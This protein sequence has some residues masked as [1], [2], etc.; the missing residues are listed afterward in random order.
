MRTRSG[1]AEVLPFPRS[2][3]FP[4]QAPVGVQHF[5][6][7]AQPAAPLPFPARPRGQ[8]EQLGQI[9]RNMRLAMKV[10]RETIARRLAISTATIDAF[11][12]G[13][14]AALPHWKET[15]RVVRGYC[16]LLRLDPEPILWRIRSQ[17]QAMSSPAPRPAPVPQSAPVAPPQYQRPAQAADDDGDGRPVGR[18]RRTTLFALTAPAVVVGAML[19]LSKTSPG[20]VYAAVA[21]L[22]DRIEVPMRAGL[23]YVLLLTSPSRDG[24]RWIDIGDP[25]LRKTDKLHTSTR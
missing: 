13:A 14:V 16:E 6:P 18:R 11:E 5:A 22:P 21:W 10:P 19:V 4:A 3:R 8:D 7:Q 2:A 17:L 25:Q 9:F 20:P 24:L 1:P 15:C 23:D 12:T